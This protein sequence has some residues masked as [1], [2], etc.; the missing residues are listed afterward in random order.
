MYSSICTATFGIVFFGTPH[1]GS[2]LAGIGDVFAKVVRTVLRNP[3]NTFM[4][5]LKKDNLYASEL[6]SSFQQLQENYRYLNFYETLPLK[7]FGIVSSDKYVWCLNSSTNWIQIVE[8]K[9]AI[10]GLPDYRETKVGLNAHHEAICQYASEDSDSY[11]YVSSLIVDFVQSAMVAPKKTMDRVPSMVESFNSLNTTLVDNDWVEV[12][13]PGY[14]G[15]LLSTKE[16]LIEHTLTDSDMA[17]M[18]PYSRNQEFVNRR[19]IIEKLKSRLQSIG[20]AHSR[21]AIFGLGGVG[22]VFLSNKIQT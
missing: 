10:L 11:K 5:A 1:Q 2:S 6:L 17:V 8:K 22:F 19:P 12:D 14:C 4:S 3:G 20:K 16:V 13:E 21:L 18:I 15:C 9:S 7:S